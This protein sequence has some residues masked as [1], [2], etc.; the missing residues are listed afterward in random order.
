MDFR[1]KVAVLQMARS[2][3]R[4]ASASFIASTLT[5]VNGDNFNPLARFARFMPGQA[6]GSKPAN[7]GS[8]RARWAGD[9]SMTAV[10]G[11]Q[12]SANSGRSSPAPKTPGGASAIFKEV[13]HAFS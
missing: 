9:G 4:T 10:D 13:Q 11:C 3:L 12:L 2:G 7:D 8:Y 1:G 5:I 6:V